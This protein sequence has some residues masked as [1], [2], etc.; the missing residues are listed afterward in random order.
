MVSFE[1]LIRPVGYDDF[2]KYSD[3]FEMEDIVYT[4][5][6]ILE[7]LPEFEIKVRFI[8]KKDIWNSRGKDVCKNCNSIKFPKPYHIHE[9]SCKCGDS[10]TLNEGCPKCKEYQDRELPG[11]I[12]TLKIPMG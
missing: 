10:W 4:V 2:I 12:E 6:N 9:S 1:V 7:T 11:W 8:T 3:E 5:N